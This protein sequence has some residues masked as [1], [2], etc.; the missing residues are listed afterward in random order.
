MRATH[1]RLAVVALSLV[2]DASAGAQSRG[3]LLY[4]THCI[5]CHTT[6]M[7]WRDNR[8]ASDWPSLQAQVRR[9]QGA[10]SLGWTEGDIL[11]VTRYLNDSIYRFE[12]P[13]AAVRFSA[14]QAPPRP[15]RAWKACAV[16]QATRCRWA[17]TSAGNP[18]M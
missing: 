15:T 2:A 1:W 9:W 7:H 13:L 4:A 17:A 14:D 3:E 10:A 11:A 12:Q 5:A 8:T 6:Q 18:A 16:S